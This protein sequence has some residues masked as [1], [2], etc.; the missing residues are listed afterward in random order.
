MFTVL[1]GVKNDEHSVHVSLREIPEVPKEE[2]KPAEVLGEKKEKDV[3]STETTLPNTGQYT[4]S[5]AI[6]VALSLTCIGYVMLKLNKESK[7]NE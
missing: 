6:V 7:E 3:T 4:S 5:F 1:Y 2:N